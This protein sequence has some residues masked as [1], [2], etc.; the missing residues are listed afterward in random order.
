METKTTHYNHNNNKKALKNK[1]Q[2]GGWFWTTI[3]SE[4]QECRNPSVRMTFH[5][6]IKVSRKFWTPMTRVWPSPSIMWL[7]LMQVR[8]LIT[9]CSTKSIFMQIKK[10]PQTAWYSRRIRIRNIIMIIN[11]LSWVREVRDAAVE[12]GR[13]ITQVPLPWKVRGT[14]P[15]RWTNTTK[16]YLWVRKKEWEMFNQL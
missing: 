1:W 3:A 11:E 8:Q 2:P 12:S 14:T 7:S 5:N 16:T 6:V 13:A 15:L 4:G 10:Y 9:C